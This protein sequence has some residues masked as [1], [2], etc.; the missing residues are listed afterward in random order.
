MVYSSDLCFDIRIGDKY[1]QLFMPGYDNWRA[2]G[3]EQRVPILELP[4]DMR[5]LSGVSSAFLLF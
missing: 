5:A 3:G 4:V 2:W 1:C